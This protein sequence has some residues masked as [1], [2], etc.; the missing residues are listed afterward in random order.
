MLRLML[1]LKDYR[2]LG[3]AAVR[4]WN[5]AM[6]HP[7]HARLLMAE[8]ADA[9]AR[10]V[11]AL[12]PAAAWALQR[13]KA[14]IDQQQQALQQARA[15]GSLCCAHLGCTNMAAASEAQVKGKLCSGCRTVRFCSDACSQA[16]WQQHKAA[17]KLLQ[18]ERQAQ[19]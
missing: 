3:P 19:G 4:R 17:C 7:R 9:V 18:R 1:P 15:L 16:A 2:T 8:D 11:T 13:L 5:D 6:E 12:R 14:Q 10:L